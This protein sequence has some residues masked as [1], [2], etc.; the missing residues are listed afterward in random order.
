MAHYRLPAMPDAAAVVAEALALALEDI[1]AADELLRH[2][3]HRGCRP[4]ALLRAGI[5]QVKRESATGG[6]G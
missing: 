5:D 4:T 1:D 2:A 6:D 3:V